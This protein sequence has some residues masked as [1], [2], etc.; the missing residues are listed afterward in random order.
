MNRH[1]HKQPAAAVDTTAVNISSAVDAA[2]I[3]A[4]DSASPQ[5]HGESFV[6]PKGLK[7]TKSREAV[8]QELEKEQLP[9]TAL[10]LFEKLQQGKES[11]WLSTIYRVLESFIEKNAVVK[12]MP[13][14][15]TMAV[16]EWNR[17]THMHYAVCVDCHSMVPI[18]DCPFEYVIPP[19]ADGDFHIVGHN[20]E[21]FGYC[22]KCFRKKEEEK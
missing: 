17:H 22:D 14:D 8:M 5:E 7:R 21:L 19:V 12:S 1:E 18:R 15:S 2:G 9:V 6:W 10:Y 13:T 4:A 11:I 20:L 16:Y 3:T